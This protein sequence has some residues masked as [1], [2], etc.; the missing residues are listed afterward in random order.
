MLN[1]LSLLDGVGAVVLVVTA[2]LAQHS[3]NTLGLQLQLCSYV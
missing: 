2:T 1:L 3:A